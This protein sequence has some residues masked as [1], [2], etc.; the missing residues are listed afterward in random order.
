MQEGF[1]NHLQGLLFYHKNSL[2][3]LTL[4]YLNHVGSGP[5]VTSKAKHLIFNGIHPRKESSPDVIQ[6]DFDLFI[7]T[8]VHLQFKVMRTWVRYHPAIK[9]LI[10]IIHLRIAVMRY[11]YLGGLR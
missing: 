11:I 7:R 4:Y 1:F 6:V 8:G 5:Q 2:L 9:Q 3:V 10:N